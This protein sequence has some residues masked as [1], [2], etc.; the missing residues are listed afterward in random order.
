MSWYDA[1]YKRR[2]AVTVLAFG[3]TGVQA[4]VDVDIEV[5]SDWDGFWDNIRSDFKDVVVT[6]N[7]GNLLDF[8]RENANYANRELSLHV[9]DLTISHDNSANVVFIYF[10]YPD[11]TTDHSTTFTISSPKAGKIILSAPHSRLVA[12]KSSTNISQQP[13]QTFTK[14]SSEEIHVFFRISSEL[15]TRI[16]SYNDRSN[17]EEIDYFY[18]K[19]LDSSGTNADSRYD[20]TQLRIGNGFI[21]ATFKGG[22]DDTTYA[23]LLTYETT[24][25]QVLE[26]RALLFVNDVLP[27]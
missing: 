3:G 20:Q 21:R 14:A 5:P 27:D 13:L 1:D 12:A 19:S 18:I 15:A 17:Q 10:F 2:Q 4:T 11:E 24:L 25:K 6:D 16:E 26:S 7:K 9:N 22:D 8:K 23:M